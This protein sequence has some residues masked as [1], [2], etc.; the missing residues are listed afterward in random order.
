MVRRTDDANLEVAGFEI[1]VTAGH[2][3]SLLF[4][5]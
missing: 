4:H 3:L 5:E 1:A 2:R